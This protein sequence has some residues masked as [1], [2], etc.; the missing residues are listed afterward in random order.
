VCRTNVTGGAASVL[1]PG[2]AV[3]F[4]IEAGRTGDEAVI[5]R[6]A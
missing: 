1:S 4:D 2:Q 3:E 6:N 5:V